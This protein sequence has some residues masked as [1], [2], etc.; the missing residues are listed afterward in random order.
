MVLSEENQPL[1]WRYDGLPLDWAKEIPKLHAH[2]EAYY[3]SEAV[4]AARER[5][6]HILLMPNLLSGVKPQSPFPYAAIWGAREALA[7]TFLSFVLACGLA[8]G[9]FNRAGLAA[10]RRALLRG[11]LLPQPG[12]ERGLITDDEEALAWEQSG[13]NLMVSL[14]QDVAAMLGVKQHDDVPLDDPD[15]FHVTRAC[16]HIFSALGELSAMDEAGSVWKEA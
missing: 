14:A 8:S 9:N 2:L 4:L 11:Q 10:A 15:G 1:D 5:E 13:R 6:L 7:E 3:A 12:P 16:R